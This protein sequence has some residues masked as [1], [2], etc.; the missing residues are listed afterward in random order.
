MRLAAEP[1]RG[2]S[3]DGSLPSLVRALSIKPVRW[4]GSLTTFEQS[5]PSLC[6]VPSRQ[7]TIESAPRRLAQP[8]ARPSRARMIATLVSAPAV[9]VKAGSSFERAGRVGHEQHH[10]FAEGDDVEG[11]GW[12]RGR[13][14]WA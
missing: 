13:D 12:R 4:A 10:R 6:I 14:C 11:A 9:L 5:M 1:A 7:L 3:I 8:T 2:Y